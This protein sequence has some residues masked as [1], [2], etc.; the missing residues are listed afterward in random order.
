[1]LPSAAASE[2]RPVLGRVGGANPRREVPGGF[3]DIH[4]PSRPVVHLSANPPAAPERGPDVLARTPLAYTPS[5]DREV[6]AVKT[7]EETVIDRLAR[8]I[9][10]PSPLAGFELRFRPQEPGPPP[11]PETAPAS[12]EAQPPAATAPA[13]PHPAVSKPPAAPP[14]PPVDINAIADK[15]YQTLQRRQLRMQERKGFY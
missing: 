11:A 10:F 1:M 13:E 5:P 14:A 6:A 3:P 2:F 4:A 12:A 9:V 8:E 7:V 15:V